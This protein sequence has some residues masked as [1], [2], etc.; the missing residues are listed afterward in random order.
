M[1]ASL[2]PWLLTLC[3]KFGIYDLPTE[4]KVHKNG[5]PRLGGVVFVPAMLIGV[6]V[7]VTMMNYNG[8]LVPETIHTSS[9]VIAIGAGLLYFIGIVDDLIGVSAWMKFFLQII[10]ALSFPLCGLYLNSFYGFFGIET[11]PDWLSYVITVI[12]T[13]LIINAYNLIDGIDGLAAG[14][15]IIALSV[16]GYLFYGLDT[17][18]FVITCA[19]I[20]GVLVAFLFYN[21]WGDADK[22]RKTFMGDSGSLFLGVVLSYF[23]MKYAMYNSATLPYRPD[24]LLVAITAVIVPCFDLC[25][26]A[27]CRIRRHQSIFHADKTHLHHKFLAAGLTMSQ[28]LLAILILQV[29]FLALNFTLFHLRVGLEWILLADVLIYVVINV[30]LPVFPEVATRKRETSYDN[31]IQPTETDYQGVEGLVSVIM[32]TYNAAKF[33]ADSIESIIAQTYTNWELI[34]TDDKSSDDTIDILRRYAARDSRIVVQ[35][36]TVNSGAGFSRNA[37]IAKARGQY[38]AFCDSDDRWMPT[39]LERQVQFMKDRDVR[40]CFAPYYTCNELNEYLG[41]VPAPRHVNLFSTMCDDKVGFLTCIYDA[42]QCGKHFMPLQ[43]KRQD[44]AFLLNLMRTCP[45]AYSVQEPLGHYRLHQNNI[46]GNKIS[47]IKYNALTYCVVFD[48]PKTLS[49]VFLFTFFM[50]TYLWKRMKNL[51]INISRTQLG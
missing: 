34:I 15:A 27:I 21:V 28:T 35:E 39:K 6:V 25:R 3:Y 33:V 22:K 4:R 13:I 16:Y 9:V 26:V 32:P 19:S 30:V 51:L 43:R 17:D 24:G 50:P 11:I 41:Y 12:I 8:L 48:W 37:S 1:A 42:S 10:A 29:S 31:G 45:H 20:V 5:I 47:L 46:S 2:L 49:Y 23:T 40:I 7:T 38:I 18:F 44:Y 36:N 14:L